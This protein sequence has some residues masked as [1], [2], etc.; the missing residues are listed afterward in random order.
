VDDELA[1]L[2]VASVCRPAARALARRANLR[3]TLQV[4]VS[5]R[6]LQLFDCAA[7][8]GTRAASGPLQET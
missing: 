5:G 7:W 8:T 4:F 1:T 3:Y 6:I 2:V